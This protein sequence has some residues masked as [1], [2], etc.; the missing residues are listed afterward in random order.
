VVYIIGL[1]VFLVLVFFIGLYAS[2]KIDTFSGFATTGGTLPLFIVFFTLFS[3]YLGPGSTFGWA[4]KAFNSGIGVLPSIFGYIVFMLACA[5]LVAQRYRRFSG[6]YQAATF[7]D[8][9]EVRFDHKMRAL[10]SLMQIGA[11][12][13]I[14]AGSMRGM[15]TVLSAI[16]PSLSVN[17]GIIIT[18][19]ILIVYTSWGGLYSVAYTD[20]FQGIVSIIGISALGIYMFAHVGGFAGISA[21]YEAMGQTGLL[22]SSSID[23]GPALTGFLVF[24]IGS[25]PFQDITQRCFAAKNARAAKTAMIL[26]AVVYGLVIFCGSFMIGLAGHVFFPDI[27][28]D[29]VVTQSIM[30]F[31]PP[32]LGVVVFMGLLGAAMSTG[33]SALII[34]TINFMEDFY[35]TYVKKDIDDVQML[36][37]TKY[38]TLIFG[39]ITMII[40]IYA[41]SIYNLFYFSCD[42]LGA[43]AAIPLLIALYWKR[44]SANAA[45]SGALAG[46]VLWVIMNLGGYA[47][48]GLGPIFWG[49]VLNFFVTWAATSFMPKGTSE[50]DKV[51]KYYH[52]IEAKE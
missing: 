14:A 49:S 12:F 21:G 52:I 1:I 31:F 47:P 30:N 10:T 18:S 39:I 42:I 43:S 36:K 20:V 26:F 46:T 37:M 24:F 19:I 17:G 15:G 34:P 22:S 50:Q 23:F 33:D 44:P 27:T 16:I 35:K 2:K 45:F 32:I 5:F 25:L 8:L 41:P 29:Q 48:L 51:D 38:L 6:A 7:G 9:M 28:A 13:A 3:T 40:A 4:E 11:F